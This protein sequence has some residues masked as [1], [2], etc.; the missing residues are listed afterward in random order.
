MP[1]CFMLL[2]ITTHTE[3]HPHST[4][5]HAQTHTVE[6]FTFVKK[7]NNTIQTVPDYDT[8]GLWVTGFVGQWANGTVGFPAVSDS[9]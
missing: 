3:T 5:S 2:Y 4:A 7:F 6:N 9:V 1:H 8:V